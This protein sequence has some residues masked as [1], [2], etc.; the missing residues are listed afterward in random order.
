M[1]RP[2]PSIPDNLAVLST[3][4]DYLA[5]HRECQWDAHDLA[6]ALGF[7]EMEVQSALEALT[8]EDELL[9]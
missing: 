3:V 9:R 1:I 2:E 7:P 8:I 4:R 5:R 6:D